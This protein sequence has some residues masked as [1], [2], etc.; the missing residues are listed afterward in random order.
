MTAINFN[1]ID[2]VSDCKLTCHKKC[3]PKVTVECGKEVSAT[4]GGPS[5]AGSSAA[6][7]VS[8]NVFGVPLHLL[9]TGNGKVPMVVERLITTI[10]MYGLYTEGVYR[11]SGVSTDL[12]KILE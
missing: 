2:C 9:A 12:D 3:Y 6:G 10:E 7:V 5:N 1:I 8:N 11:K 4:D